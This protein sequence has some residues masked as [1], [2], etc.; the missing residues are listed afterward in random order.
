M[1]CIA[2]EGCEKNTKTY[3]IKPLNKSKLSS[4]M[5]IFHCL[6]IEPPMLPQLKFLW[7]CS[8]TDLI[9][10]DGYMI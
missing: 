7:L 1:I 6:L 5:K 4:R 3:K 8:V 2:E 10:T 9:L